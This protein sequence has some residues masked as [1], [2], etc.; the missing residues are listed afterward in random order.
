MRLLAAAALT[1]MAAG[2][3]GGITGAQSEAR[4][5]PVAEGLGAGSGICLDP[6]DGGETIVCAVVL[7]EGGTLTLGVLGTGKSGEQPAFR[8]R[9][10]VDGEGVERDMESRPVMEGF[11]YV[12]TPL[13]PD[14]PLWKRLRAGN[15]LSLSSSP[16]GEPLD[17]SLRGSAKE[18]ERVAAACR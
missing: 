12:R 14:E 3:S 13:E 17:Y 10:E 4:W 2:M 16:E 18:L 5:G 11:L 9:I 6:K 7:C 15:R 1:V 8:G